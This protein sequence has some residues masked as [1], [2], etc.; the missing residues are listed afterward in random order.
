MN[1]RNTSA[2]NKFSQV[3]D[4]V[5]GVLD[6]ALVGDGRPEHPQRLVADVLG[7][8]GLHL[9]QVPGDPGVDGVLVGPVVARPPGGAAVL[10]HG[11]VCGVVWCGVV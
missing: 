2:S 8:V 11:V 5:D 4:L 7:Q 3:A 9:L 6:G 1:H 10:R